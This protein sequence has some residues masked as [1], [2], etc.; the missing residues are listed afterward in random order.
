MIQRFRSQK[1][2]TL[3][4]VVA[5]GTAIIGTSIFGI[6]YG[7]QN[8]KDSRNDSSGIL[9]S[10]CN[11]SDIHHELGIL[12]HTF[13]DKVELQLTAECLYGTEHVDLFPTQSHYYFNH[14][15]LANE[16]FDIHMH[17]DHNVQ[18]CELSILTDPFLV[19]VD[20]QEVSPRESYY[21]GGSL[22]ISKSSSVYDVP[23]VGL[24]EGMEELFVWGGTGNFKFLQEF[25]TNDSYVVEFANETFYEFCRIDNGR[26]TFVESDIFDVLIECDEPCP[27]AP[28]PPSL[29]S[30]KIGGF[31]ET[32]CS[33]VDLFLY[34]DA[35]MVESLHTNKSSFFTF[36]REFEK[37]DEYAIVGHCPLIGQMCNITNDS[38]F[39]KNSNITNVLVECYDPSPSTIESFE[40]LIFH[41]I[42]PKSHVYSFPVTIS[43][44]QNSIVGGEISLSPGKL[45]VL[46]VTF[47]VNDT[48]ELLFSNPNHEEACEISNPM[49]VFINRSISVWVNC[50][51]FLMPVSILATVNAEHRGTT[52]GIGLAIESGNMLNNLVLF[53]GQSDQPKED[54]DI[55]SIVESGYNMTF[56]LFGWMELTPIAY[57]NR[58]NHLAWFDGLEYQKILNLDNNFDPTNP[59]IPLTPT[60]DVVHVGCD[61]S[62]W[63]F[64]ATQYPP[65]TSFF[66]FDDVFQDGMYVSH[67]MKIGNTNNLLNI[68][69]VPRKMYGSVDYWMRAMHMGLESRM[70]NTITTNLSF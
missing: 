35:T 9:P 5:T 66:L 43:W 42:S 47:Y 13:Q 21:L 32:N 11:S 63:V 48:Y 41:T 62:Y 49:G 53:I 38:G 44:T 50:P 20:C 12:A 65:M 22:F 28:P 25:E 7:V 59:A 6:L 23:F 14:T 54:M 15:L 10:Y 52:S 45:T 2:T 30:R 17:Y 8:D 68:S 4:A 37:G 3:V 16:T 58:Y 61:L 40:L 19:H 24:I 46:N 67:H 57:A 34:H 1:K 31:L 18:E 27:P 55:S 64:N 51:I 29:P 69:F 26:G 60:L 39:V 56:S 70:S 36:T 33:D